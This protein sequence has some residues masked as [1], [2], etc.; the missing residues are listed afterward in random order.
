VGQTITSTTRLV[1]RRL[2]DDDAVFLHD[3][4]SRP[5]VFEPLEM[6]PSEGVAE[7]LLR[8]R[9]FED[10]FGPRGAFGIW[11]LALIKGPL[12]GLIMLKP[13][14]PLADHDGMEVGWRLH[15]DFWGKGYATEGAFGLLHL[16]FSDRHLA[17]VFAVV[18]ISNARSRAVADR[19][20]MKRVGTLDYAG[21]P[22]E[23]LRMG[24]DQW[25]SSPEG[26]PLTAP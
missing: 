11:A 6:E 12:I 9:Q 2:V 7:E 23:L 16:A 21:L 18:R 20:G 10:R 4:H 14:R 5:E 3:L 15:P 13:L 26:V 17:E 1:V 24:L 19:I 22:H 25:Q 8:I